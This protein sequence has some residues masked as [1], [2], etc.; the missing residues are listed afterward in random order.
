MREAHFLQLVLFVRFHTRFVTV[1]KIRNFLL[2][3]GMNVCSRESFNQREPQPNF[4][5]FFSK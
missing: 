4:F 2:K 1:H 3:Q 5:I